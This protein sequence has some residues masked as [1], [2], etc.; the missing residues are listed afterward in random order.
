MKIKIERFFFTAKLR[1]FILII[2]YEL[3][4]RNNEFVSLTQ[5]GAF[6]W[7]AQRKGGWQWWRDVEVSPI[8]QFLVTIT[9][10][11]SNI[12]SPVCPN[13]FFFFIKF[14]YLVSK[15]YTAKLIQASQQDKIRNCNIFYLPS[16]NKLIFETLNYRGNIYKLCCRNFKVWLPHYSWSMNVCYICGTNFRCPPHTSYTQITL[17]RDVVGVFCFILNVNR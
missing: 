1:P 7:W 17:S 11:N 9:H 13:M 12:K 5:M 15:F 14:Q 2:S 3:F 6:F 10:N 4:K 16:L 8:A